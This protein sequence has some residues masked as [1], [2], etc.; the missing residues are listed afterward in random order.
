M[1]MVVNTRC[2]C[3][4]NKE[5]NKHNGETEVRREGRDKNGWVT[6]GA[7]V[8]RGKSERKEIL[9]HRRPCSRSI[10]SIWRTYESHNRNLGRMC[11]YR[12]K[13][14]HSGPTSSVL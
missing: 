5:R 1:T 9:K 11:I 14:V 2:A 13:N 10:T 3:S 12:E 4:G 6:T 8:H 7:H